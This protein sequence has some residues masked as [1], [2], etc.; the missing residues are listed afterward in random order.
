MKVGVI[1]DTH[2]FLHPQ[3]PE[4]FQG[5]DRI[6]HAGDVGG[7]EVFQ[8]LHLIAPVIGVRGNYDQELAGHL[9]PDPSLID[10][11]GIP[12]LL[13]HR[14][15]AFEW[16]SGKEEFAR[17]VRQ[18]AGHPKLIIFGHTHFPVAEE[19]DGLYFLNP[20]YCGPDPLEWEPSVGILDLQEGKV[21][22]KIISLKN[23]S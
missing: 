8:K 9:L 2:G 23:R 6:L 3:V 13:T 22:G 17:A 5:V 12:T 21:S 10:L 20:G 14:L 15:I 1:A 18:F 16:S 4:V 7:R 19:V 11:D